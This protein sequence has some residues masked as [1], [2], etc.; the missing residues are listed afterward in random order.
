[1]VSE[2]HLGYIIRAGRNG[3]GDSTHRTATRRLAHRGHLS[4]GLKP[5]PPSHSGRTQRTNGVKSG[6]IEGYDV[7]LVKRTMDLVIAV[8][9]IVV[10]FP[11]LFAAAAWIKLTSPGPIFFLQRRV[12]RDGR[13]FRMVKFRS[14]RVGV[15]STSLA[16]SEDDPRIT[17]VGQL[18]R[19]T[20][21]DEV[22]QLWN[23]IRRE[24]AVVGPRPA[25]PEM[26]PHYTDE[27]RQRLRVRPGLTGWA[28][29]NGRNALPYHQ[30]LEKDVWYVRNW[31]VW[32]D[33]RILIKTLPALVSQ[34]G[35]YQEDPRPWERQPTA[36]KR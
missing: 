6:P 34:R 19:K 13:E 12:G 11:L 16:N 1:M 21:F 18:L 15:D 25:L 4:G 17:R 33:V 10:A 35:L 20:A 14:M 36:D 27:Q 30:R 23:V 2:A 5:M 28:Q 31:S 3:R 26:V 22:P 7:L 24:M 8:T 9:V 29:V 32:L